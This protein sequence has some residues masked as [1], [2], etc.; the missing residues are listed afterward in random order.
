MQCSFIFT[1]KVKQLP[2][3]CLTN[4]MLHICTFCDLYSRPWALCV[5]CIRCHKACCQGDQ[6]QASTCVHSLALARCILL[7]VVFFNGA[8]CCLFPGVFHLLLKELWQASMTATMWTQGTKKKKKK[9]QDMHLCV[10]SKLCQVPSNSRRGDLALWTQQ[11]TPSVFS[12]SAWAYTHNTVGRKK[13]DNFGGCN[14]C[15]VKEDSLIFINYTY[16]SARLSALLSF[17]LAASNNDGL[18]T[19]V[20]NYIQRTEPRAARNEMGNWYYFIQPN[21]GELSKFEVSSGKGQHNSGFI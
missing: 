12:S 2:N 7:V 13:K 1:F 17:L 14:S 15:G 6:D 9:R 18:S 11:H 8:A 20:W 4:W 21:C 19:S 16:I 10:L 5:V 3:Q